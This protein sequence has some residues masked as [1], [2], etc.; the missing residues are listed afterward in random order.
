[1]PAAPDPQTFETSFDTLVDTH[2]VRL[3][4]FAYRMLGSWDLAEDAVQQVLFKIWKRRLPL[5][6]EEPLPYLYQAVRNQCLI[7][8]RR[9]AR[10]GDTALR[11]AHDIADS[12]S[13][14]AEQ[15]ELYGAVDRAIAALPERCRLVFTMSRE[16]DLTYTEIARILNISPKTVENQMVRALKALRS[17][18][19]PY[20]C[21][22][23]A[24]FLSK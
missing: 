21:G 17:A 4:S 1:M 12:G 2:Y 19:G 18:L 24:L 6:F 16:Q 23:V 10:R 3:T 14:P 9:E 7:P 20:L 22:A 8:L 5:N 11:A 15:A 13:D